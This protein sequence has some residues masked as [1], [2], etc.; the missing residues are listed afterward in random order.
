GQGARGADLRVDRLRQ[1]V[2][3][4]LREAARVDAIGLARG[5]ALE[6]AHRAGPVET[7][8]E[9]AGARDAHEDER[10]RQ[11]DAGAHGCRPRPGV[12]SALYIT[13]VAHRPPWGRSA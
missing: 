2:A 5:V 9:L 13:V 3:V 12:A 7:A 10:G 11:D 6:G 4:T 8:A 1:L